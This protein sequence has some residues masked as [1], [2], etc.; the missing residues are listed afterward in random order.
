MF[1]PGISPK[2]RSSQNQLQKASW[3]RGLAARNLIERS[4]A[5]CSSSGTATGSQEPGKL[6]GQPMTVCRYTSCTP[7][8]TFAGQIFAMQLRADLASVCIK[9]QLVSPRLAGQERDG[10]KLHRK[11]R[12]AELKSFQACWVRHV[13]KACAK[14]SAAERCVGSEGGRLTMGDRRW[15]SKRNGTGVDSENNNAIQRKK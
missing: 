14:K 4:D 1:L 9:T 3:N 5:V 6:K 11:N 8:Y 12:Q 2:S 15:Q 7:Y 13:P 10:Q